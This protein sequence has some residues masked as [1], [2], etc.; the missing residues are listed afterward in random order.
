[1]CTPLHAMYSTLLRCYI[2]LF[3]Y[4]PNPN[5]QVLCWTPHLPLYA[6]VVYYHQRILFK[7]SI[8]QFQA[9]ISKITFYQ[10]SDWY[11]DMH[12]SDFPSNA[13]AKGIVNY[14]DRLINCKGFGNNMINSENC[15]PCINCI[16]PSKR[17]RQWKL[18][19]RISL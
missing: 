15:L 12:Y 10:V 18:S 11:H 19:S 9:R 3:F 14:N 4:T 17:T 6:G 8:K 7:K 5:S 1:M 16:H 13:H 2:F